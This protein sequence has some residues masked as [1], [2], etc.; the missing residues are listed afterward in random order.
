MHVPNRYLYY[1]QTK[2]SNY[3]KKGA[4]GGLEFAV[5]DIKYARTRVPESSRASPVQTSYF[6]FQR[7]NQ[8]LQSRQIVSVKEHLHCRREGKYESKPHLS[9]FPV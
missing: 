6:S 5:S 3:I 9:L 7:A 2:I 1:Y 4:A 8:I